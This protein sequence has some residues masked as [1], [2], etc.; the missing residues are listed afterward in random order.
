MSRVETGLLADLRAAGFAVD[1]V[2]DLFG[3]RFAYRRA[4]PILLKWLPRAGSES[5]REEI[6]RALSVKWAR[7]AAAPALLELFPRVE[8]PGGLG[9]RWVIANALGGCR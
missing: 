7:P 9:S 2:S 6:V 1:V 8:D 5:L 3:K 4:V